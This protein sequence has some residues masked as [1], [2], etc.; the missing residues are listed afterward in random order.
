MWEVGVGRV[1]S[2]DGWKMGTTAT[3]Q[4]QQQRKASK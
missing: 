2:S 3:E 4:Q 1:G